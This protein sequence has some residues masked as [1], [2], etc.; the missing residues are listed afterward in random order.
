MGLWWLNDQSLDI[1]FQV[2]DCEA[3]RGLVQQRYL[4]RLLVRSFIDG[5][6]VWVIINRDVRR[7]AVHADE[8]GQVVVGHILCNIAGRV[9]E[10]S[11]EL[12]VLFVFQ[13]QFIVEGAFEEHYA[14]LP[15]INQSNKTQSYRSVVIAR[16][17]V[18]N[19]GSASMQLGQIGQL[20][21]K[22]FIHTLQIGM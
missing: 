21:I 18:L 8:I 5:S 16:D 1:L 2:Q 12:C 6:A 3:R 7:S 17:E 9:G 15:K 19:V 4:V 11:D 22:A 10:S 20:G 14:D 13:Q